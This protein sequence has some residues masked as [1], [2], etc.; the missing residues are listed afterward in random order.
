MSDI[1]TD[2]LQLILSKLTT[3]EAGNDALQASIAQ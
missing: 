1:L 2:P 3:L